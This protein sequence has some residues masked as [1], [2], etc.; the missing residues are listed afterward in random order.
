[1]RAHRP[2]K[3]TTTGYRVGAVAALVLLAACNSAR[4]A[5][6]PTILDPSFGSA[7]VTITDIGGSVHEDEPF[8]LIAD[9]EGRYVVPGKAFNRLTGNFD[10]AVLRYTTNGMLDLSFSGDGIVLTDFGGIEEALGIVEQP[11]GKLVAGG[12]TKKG[13]VDADFAL[14]R[15]NV[16][17]S[18]DL[19]FG[20][21]GKV[22]TD[23]LGGLD[24]MLAL[25]IQSDGRI[26]GAG[27][28]SQP[29][30][31][32]ND[33]AVARYNHDGSLD[34]SFGPG[35]K[36]VTDLGG[37]EEYTFRMVIQPDGKILCVGSTV[38]PPDSNVDL[39]VARYNVD[40]SL[41]GSFGPRDHPGW[42]S[43]DF[44]GGTDHGFTGA[45]LP[46]G[47]LLVGGLANNPASGSEDMV[48]VRYLSNGSIDESFAEGRGFITVD[49]FGEYDQ[50]L[51]MAIQPEGKII[52]A[53]HAKHP[54][55]HFEF[56]LARFTGDGRLDSSF[57]V[58]GRY[59]KD[60]FGGPDGLHGLVLQR[61]GKAVVAGDALNSG[62][63]GD[64]FVILRLLVADLDWTVAA[65]D[66][67]EESAYESDAARSDL[68][69]GLN[70]ANAELAAGRTA[71]A[72]NRLKELLPRL[73]GC[74][75]GE[76]SDDWLV[77][78]EAQYEIRVLVEQIIYKLGG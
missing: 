31:N 61:D 71:S 68:V 52:V 50:I 77:D 51:A 36:V 73:D 24:Q 25:A 5:T 55:R 45:A 39:A 56:A 28:A 6:I 23:F 20:E 34:G 54:E 72:V 4:A 70:A 46:D 44:Y 69:G 58:G 42:V 15:Y 53:G 60:M 65:A 13:Q 22:T 8:T 3:A 9:R 26:V 2:R 76:A 62:T 67:V 18:L 16:D 1:M 48:L 30:G 63:Q 66:E 41:D 37:G 40:G 29:G 57:G 11:D 32:R 33:F 47:T 35:G 43:T 75:K 59:S 7:G 27:F 21:G 74:G 12:F 17:G 38:N 64:D 14:A 10:F 78:C 19:S 49:F